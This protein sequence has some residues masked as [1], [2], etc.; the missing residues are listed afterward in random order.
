[1]SDWIDAESH[2]DRA[3]EMYERGRW[4][5]AESELR[6]ALS[7]NPDHPDWLYSLAVTLEAAG[8]DLEALSTYQRVI[9]L[10]DE[11]VDAYIAAGAACIRLGRC[12]TA[13]RWLEQAIRRAPDNEF[14]Y[15]HRI[16][17]LVQLGQHDEAE[18]TFYLAQQSIDEPTPQC[19]AAIAESLIE[20]RVYE[21]AGW[22][23]REC[24]RLEPKM[25]RIRARFAYVLSATQKPQRA[26]QMYLRDLRD[27]PGNIDTLIDYGELLVDLGR[28]GEAGEKFRRVL[29][30]EPANVDAHF[31]L[32]Q[33]AMESGRAE[34]AHI[35]YEL[36]L[37]LDRQ[38]P[39]I[40]L[41]LSEALLARGHVKSA[42]LHLREELEAQ[43]NC[44]STDPSVPRREPNFQDL[45]RLG[46]LLLQADLPAEA[47]RIFQSML[48]LNQSADLLRRLAIAR[49]RSGDLAGGVA[50]SRRVLRFDPS[51]L[52]A[53]HNLALAALKT[54]QLR[55]AAGW[56][57]RGLRV[58]RH[59]DGLRRL[60]MKHGL[61]WLRQHLA[62]WRS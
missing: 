14:A 22:C 29:E 56:I 55:V 27:D 41:A 37:K 57:A 48:R 7:L 36:V 4:A 61:A 34:Q 1:M 3:L 46:E 10:D 47:A 38:F 50:A 5:E 24:L 17:A 16:D 20:R 44:E 25:P 2:A 60:R 40:R 12:R 13:L 23:L 42:R 59:D 31:R 9:E 43:A 21:R 11:L 62:W 6:K 32:G 53:I 45:D 52:T 26:V 35:E 28:L 49:F 58:D 54:G 51:C 18:A 39:C 33:V 19:L 8:R 30:L 15:A